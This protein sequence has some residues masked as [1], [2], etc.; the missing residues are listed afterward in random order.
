LFAGVNGCPA[1]SVVATQRRDVPARALLEGAEPTAEVAS[2]P[3]RLALWQRQLEQ[4]RAEADKHTV[5]DVAGCGVR[6][7]YVCRD[8]AATDFESTCEPSALFVL[9]M[10]P[11]PPPSSGPPGR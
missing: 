9:H 4:A 6:D 10:M 8:D 1:G 3:A 2:N 7:R 11:P 5:F